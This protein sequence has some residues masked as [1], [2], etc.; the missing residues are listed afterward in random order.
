MDKDNLLNK[1]LKDVNTFY[2]DL[3]SLLPELNKSA[4]DSI[5]SYLTLGK[6][7]E[8]WSIN[9]EIF[10]EKLLKDVNDNDDVIDYDI[11]NRFPPF[12]ALLPCGLRNPFVTLFDSF[13]EIWGEKQEALIEGNV[14]HELSYY[15]YA[16]TIDHIDSLPDLM[17]TSDINTLFH[18]R[19]QEKFVNI[20]SFVDP[21]AVV[22]PL[23]ERS[24][25]VDPEKR[26]SF[27]A[28]NLLVAVVVKDKL[29]ERE[30]P[31][32]WEDLL[33]PQFKNSIGVRGEDDFFC[34]SVSIPYYL[35][36]GEDG[37]IKLAR[38]IEGRYHPAEMVKLCNSPKPDSPTIFI[39][40]WFFA[41]RIVKQDKNI[42]IFPEEG[43]FTSPVSIFVKK[44]RSKRFKEILDFLKGEKLAQLC[45]EL[46][47]PSA[48]SSNSPEFP[49]DKKLYWIG[50]D[51]L[52][53]SDLKDIKE[54]I[55]TIYNNALETSR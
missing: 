24:G 43:A 25:M 33:D 47:F 30:I 16:D 5:A 21:E 22:N 39:M 8:L 48:Y 2:P 29:G 42:V 50:W 17:I 10:M 37:I 28:T 53:N 14:N 46:W 9:S 19:F 4:F 11:K 20:G 27:I 44:S 13:I 45:E 6:A 23:F 40:P 41:Q 34:H 15:E 36:Y 1:T 54:T 51:T 32:R 26:Y 31:K 55:D 49:E 18:K 52:R 3:L 12:V 7:L 38:N 35:L